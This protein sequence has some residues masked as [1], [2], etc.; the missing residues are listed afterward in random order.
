MSW[1]SGHFHPLIRHPPNCMT[2]DVMQLGG[3]EAPLVYE[4][5]G[6]LAWRIFHVL[7]ME[8]TFYP[9]TQNLN[10]LCEFFNGGYICSANF[11]TLFA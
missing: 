9:Q 5:E 8:Y 11:V 10:V 1:I 7:A 6:Y 4:C 2:S 3:G